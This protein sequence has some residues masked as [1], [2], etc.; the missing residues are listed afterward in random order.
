M[1]QKILIGLALTLTIMVFILAYWITEPRRQEAA[2]ER[3][4]SE[5]AQR[6]AELYAEHC[7]SCHGV[8]GEGKAG[9]AIQE[10]QLSP[11]ALEKTIARGLPETGMPAWSEEDGGLLKGHQIDDLVTF[12]SSWEDTLVEEVAVTSGTE[13]ERPSVT[14]APAKL[15]V[16]PSTEPGQAIFEQKCK[17]CHT[18]GGGRTI[19]P[20]LKGITRQ[21]KR[22]WLIRV[23]VSPKELLA[24]EDPLLKQLVQEYDGLIMPNI[25]L[26]PEEAEE[27]LAYLE[28]Q[29]EEPKPSPPE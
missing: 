23:I 26:S 25:G 8:E 18:I 27:V 12:I 7:A 17:S 22:D 1:Q 21:R 29:S 10:S 14:Q 16:T 5:A 15:S 20:D 11:S 3:Q 24:Q 19:G 9:P 2:G 28:A 13:I 4:T 6:G